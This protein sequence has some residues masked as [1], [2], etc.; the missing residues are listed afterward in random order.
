[1]AQ[2]NLVSKKVRMGHR[3][4]IKYQLV[5][6]CFINDIQLS[7]NELDCL[8]LLGAYGEHELSEFCNV[9]VTEKIFKTAQTVRNFLT[10]AGKVKLV[11][12]DGTNK[13]RISLTDDLKIQT[14]GNIVLDF[15]VVYVTES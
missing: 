8:A 6:H 3:D 9:T 5:T 15:K 14:E 4:I 10:K 13:K 1:M 2:A 12:K 7:S 11:N